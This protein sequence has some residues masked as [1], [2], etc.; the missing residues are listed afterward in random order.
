MAVSP[1]VRSL[2][3]Q[4]PPIEWVMQMPGADLRVAVYLGVAGLLNPFLAMF[5]GTITSHAVHS[6]PISLGVHPHP[7]AHSVNAQEDGSGDNSNAATHLW[8]HGD[9]ALLSKSF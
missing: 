6:L 2:G 4:W 8:H 3:R 7:A 1:V 9:V 5:T